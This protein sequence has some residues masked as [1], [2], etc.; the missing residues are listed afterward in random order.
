MSCGARP[1]KCRGIVGQSGTDGIEINV[2]IAAQKVIFAVNEARLV[3]PFPQS[4]GPL[5][6]GVELA[7]ILA[8]ELLHHAGDVTLF[9][10][11][12]EQMHMVVHQ[13]VSVK[14]AARVK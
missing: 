3:A 8:A 9:R 5:V 2:P 12:D 1:K 10:W 11:R 4:A 13:Y 14:D 7:Y 6:S